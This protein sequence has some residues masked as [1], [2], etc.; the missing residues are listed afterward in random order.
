MYFFT[1]ACSSCGTSPFSQQ[2]NQ[3]SSSVPNTSY[4]APQ[5]GTSFGSNAGSNGG[6]N[7]GSGSS[8]T[9]GGT[10]PSDSNFG[11]T[12]GTTGNFGSNFGS[13]GA[14]NRQYLPPRPSSQNPPQ[15]PFDEKYGYFY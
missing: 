2:Y 4:G 13:Q 9:F 3:A 7:F 8:G 12:F 14:A 15:Q 11:S 10:E 5:F 1:A 6:S